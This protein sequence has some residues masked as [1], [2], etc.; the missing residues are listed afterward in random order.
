MTF[1]S[2][3]KEQSS[4]EEPENQRGSTIAIWIPIG[5]GFG[6]PLGLV[7]D[8]LA[9]GIAI[10]AAI[11]IAIGATM[12]QRRKGVEVENNGKQRGRLPL[13]IGT[14]VLLLLVGAATLVFLLLK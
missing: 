9:L 8:N 4:N 11:G 10:G 6:I 3:K 12:D 5:V 14:G 7:F 2:D 1:E 13:V